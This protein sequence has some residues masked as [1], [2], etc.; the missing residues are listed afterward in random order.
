MDNSALF[1]AVFLKLF[2]SVRCLRKFCIRLLERVSVGELFSGCELLDIKG[3]GDQF[4]ERY[5]N[6]C[7]A[8]YGGGRRCPSQN[9][10]AHRAAYNAVRRARYAARKAEMSNSGESM[11][12]NLKLDNTDKTELPAPFLLS[13]GNTVIKND[14]E[15]SKIGYEVNNKI[16]GVLNYTAITDK[17]PEEFG[18]HTKNFYQR[19]TNWE[20]DSKM[21]EISKKELADMTE[22]E[23]SSLKFFTGDGY[24]WFNDVLYGSTNMKDLRAGLQEEVLRHTKYM[25]AAMAKAPKTQKIVY[26][27]VGS[28]AKIF[29][30]ETPSKWVKQHLTVGNEIIFDGYQSST[31]SIPIGWGYSGG[32]SGVMYEILTPEGVNA[33]YISE[34][35]EEQ[36]IILPR[37]SRYT[38]L[39]VEHNKSGGSIVKLVA[40]NSKGEI[41]DGTNADTPSPILP[42]TK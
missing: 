27:G 34:Y 28:Q 32:E 3:D 25:D 5:S 22:D 38:V 1:H 8:S 29:K 26:R 23:L 9:D 15:L 39:G 14:N 11:S 7:R 31:T 16:S 42:P 10:P 12:K 37:E 4:R 18:F 36:E 35:E 21:L 6:M 30:G 17:T 20:L 13:T 33:T 24:A 41:L 2:E 40:I 19:A